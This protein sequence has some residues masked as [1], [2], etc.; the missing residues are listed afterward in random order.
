MEQVGTKSFE[1]YKKKWEQC[2]SEECAACAE[3]F[4]NELFACVCSW[5]FGSAQSKDLYVVRAE[6]VKAV[7][8]PTECAIVGKKVS[9]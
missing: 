6:D 4:G 3:K 5:D 7:G 9:K 2:A 1:E 8:R